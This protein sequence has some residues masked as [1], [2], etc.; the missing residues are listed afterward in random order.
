MRELS[1]EKVTQE[2]WFDRQF[3]IFHFCGYTDWIPHHGKGWLE[4]RTAWVDIGSS[5]HSIAFSIVLCCG[6]RNA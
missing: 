5:S 4:T 2:I 3:W 1:L 6:Y